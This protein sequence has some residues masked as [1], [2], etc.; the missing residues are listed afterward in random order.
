MGGQ[1]RLEMGTG[2]PNP[3]GPQNFMTPGPVHETKNSNPNLLPEAALETAIVP[4][5]G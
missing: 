5:C 3:W 1:Y 2:D 4:I